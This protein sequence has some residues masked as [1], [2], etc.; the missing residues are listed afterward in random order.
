MKNN[1]I[2]RLFAVSL[3]A[4]SLL[5]FTGIAQAAEP[6]AASGDASLSAGEWTELAARY[7]LYAAAEDAA[8][9]P[10]PETLASWWEALEDDTLTE[11]IL[12]SLK[13][14][15]DLQSA[16]AKVT[17]ARAA[18]GISKAA[19]LPW[20]DNTDT[21]TR[22][23]TSENSTGDGKT[24]NVY[25]LG[26]DASW[27]IDVFGG[28]RESIKAGAA[29]LEAQHASL[30]A[31]WVTLSSEVALNYLTL[32][33][34]QEQLDIANQN[35]A[36]QIDT[37]DMVESRNK[38]GLADELALSQ[39]R[40]TVE[41]TRAAIPPIRASIEQTMNALAILT[42]NIPGALGEALGEK[43]SLPKPEGVNLV[44]IPANYLRQRPDIR[45]AERQLTAQI[46]RKKS[47]EKDLLPKFHLIG[48]IG[49]ESFSTGSLFSS[50]SYGFSIGPRISL[51]IFHGGAIRNNIR[52][53]SAREEQYLAAYESAVLT[54]VAE[55]RDA[56]VK[57]EQERLRNVSLKSGVE[58]AQTALEVATDKY[59]NGLT[60]F[61]NVIGVHRS[62][63]TLQEQYVVSEG[64]VTS[65]IVRIFKALGG[66]WAPLAEENTGGS[67]SAK[68]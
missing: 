65:N 38:T 67:V 10:S 36:L 3:A 17:E 42:G 31:A 28:Q 57:N 7:P 13:N 37:L 33:T 41:Q 20:L 49:L 56:L 27:E 51:P 12:L 21:W 11:L 35:L 60:D 25:R 50:D 8:D 22:G 5:V 66:G 61:N 62:L 44:G 19:V 54:A 1:M 47:A 26:L 9:A 53:Q 18:L 52:V 4:A 2:R 46:A 34:L 68:P 48:S 55:V 24:R 40:Y 64:Q 43:K 39:A 16:R 32:R 63:L 14:N 6:A 15:R 23:K 59:A 45:A 58:A 29:A 30:H